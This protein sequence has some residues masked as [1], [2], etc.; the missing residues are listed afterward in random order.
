M[1]DVSIQTGFML[2]ML[3]AQNEQQQQLIEAQ[4][5]I[6]RLQKQLL[7]KTPTTPDE[8]V[9]WHQVSGVFA[10]DAAASDNLEMLQALHD[11]ILAFGK[12]Y[13]QPYV[14][15]TVYSEIIV[16]MTRGLSAQMAHLELEDE[17]KQHTEQQQTTKTVEFPKKP[18]PENSLQ[19][20]K[21]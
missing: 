8:D 21:E 19:A 20:V 16:H 4:Q 6:I 13:V 5:E 18:S 10:E 14:H 2:G 7:E 11:W 12:K 15:W 3:L 1:T 17:D 9:R